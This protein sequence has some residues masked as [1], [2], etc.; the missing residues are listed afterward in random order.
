MNEKESTKIWFKK[1]IKFNQITSNTTKQ[2]KL[3]NT[4][5]V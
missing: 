4:K 2:K 5:K 1:H 3:M